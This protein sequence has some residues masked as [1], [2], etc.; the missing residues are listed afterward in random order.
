[1]KG[2]KWFKLVFL[3]FFVIFI[4]IYLSQ[5]L[6]FYDYQITEKKIMTEEKIKQF[7][8]DIQGNKRIDVADYLEE[9]ELEYNNEIA[10]MNNQISQFIR[11]VMKESFEIGTDVFTILFK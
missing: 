5:E 3:L 7:E 10:K 8:R 6:G 2:F 1:M 9:N 11:Y 4:T